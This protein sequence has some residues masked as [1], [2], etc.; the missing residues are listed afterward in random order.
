MKSFSVLTVLFTLALCR[1]AH[2]D[3]RPA[4]LEVDGHCIEVAPQPGTW[5]VVPDPST[6]NSFYR[7]NTVTGRVEWCTVTPPQVSCYW[8]VND[9]A[10]I[11]AH[12]GDTPL[13]S[14]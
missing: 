3:C 4:Q 5:Q 7:V 12:F 13:P 2:A 10:V 8:M 11:G 6:P 14:P 9:N 1:P